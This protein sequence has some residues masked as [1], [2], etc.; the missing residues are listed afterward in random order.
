M[1]GRT[2]TRFWPLALG[3][4]AL[5]AMF[6]ACGP[7]NS[8]SGSFDRTLS[9]QGLT[10]IHITVPAGTT[11]IIPGAG[12]QVHVH[13]EFT[14]EG[15]PWQRSADKAREIS[16]NPPISQQGSLI[17]IGGEMHGYQN[18]RMNYVIETPADT[19]VQGIAGSGNFEITGIRGPVRLTSGSGDTQIAGVQQDIEA[20]AGSGKISIAGVQGNV[21][22]SAG[23]G[24]IDIAG[25]GGTVRARTGS[26]SISVAGAS[27]A[28]T[29]DANS[30]TVNL[31]GLQRDARVQTSSGSI[32]VAGPPVAQSYWEFHASSGDVTLQLPPA[33]SFRLYAHSDSG[34]ISTDIPLTAEESD[35][36]HDL[37]VRV[38][39]GNARI[40][41]RTASGSIHLK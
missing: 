3:S 33:A 4:L 9:V 11:R 17:R 24:E 28:V 32:I 13:A 30:A 21:E 25:S 23:S 31:A 27:G 10:Q 16:G 34:R 7:L 8:S 2:H 41:I 26:G 6:A 12:T 19:E 20:V 1:Q 22:V 29:V 38:G 15:W 35:S 40:E 14:V 39:D 5:V 37:R 36:K 18:L